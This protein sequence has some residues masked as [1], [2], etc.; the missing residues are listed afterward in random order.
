METTLNTNVVVDWEIIHA[1]EGTTDEIITD[2]VHIKSV[3]AVGN[4][5]EIDITETLSQ[6]DIEMLEAEVIKEQGL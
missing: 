1:H 2:R 6:D 3:K 5:K 4:G